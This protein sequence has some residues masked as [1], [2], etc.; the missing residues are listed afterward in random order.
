MIFI[1]TVL[2]WIGGIVIVILVLLVWMLLGQ[3]GF[4]ASRAVKTE[5]Q[6]VNHT[7]NG[8]NVVFQYDWFFQQYQADQ[9]LQQQIATAQQTLTNYEATLPK[10]PSQWTWEESNQVSQDQQIVQG[11][12]NQIISVVHTYNAH[13]LEINRGIFRAHHLPKTLTVPVGTP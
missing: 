1:T 7:F 10:H 2:K 8:T 5:H 6:I 11:L 4:F 13:S 9:A 3:F 12:Q